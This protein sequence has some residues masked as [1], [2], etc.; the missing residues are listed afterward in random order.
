MS[1]DGPSLAASPGCGRNCSNSVNI[2]T[3]AD[4]EFRRRGR[5]EFNALEKRTR[6]CLR[7]W[8][9]VAEIRSTMVGKRRLTACCFQPKSSGKVTGSQSK[10]V[11]AQQA[12]KKGPRFLKS[13]KQNSSLS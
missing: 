4:T 1:V 6:S 9:H 3:G 12:L 7:A 10:I 11:F 8:S 2:D 13:V 5:R